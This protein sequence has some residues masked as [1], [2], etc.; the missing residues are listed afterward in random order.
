MSSG[1]LLQWVCRVIY[2]A[3]VTVELDTKTV[4]CFAADGIQYQ[5]QETMLWLSQLSSKSCF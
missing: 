3:F 4:V 5:K 1:H 2:K